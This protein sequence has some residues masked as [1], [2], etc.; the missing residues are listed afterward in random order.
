MV[1]EEVGLEKD[2]GTGVG[3][4]GNFFFITQIQ[5]LCHLPQEEERRLNLYLPSNVG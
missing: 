5:E 1:P 3:V 4:Q 2:M